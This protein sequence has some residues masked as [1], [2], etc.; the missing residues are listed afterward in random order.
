MAGRFG[1]V[2]F[3]GHDPEEFTSVQQGLHLPS[4]VCNMSFGSGA[5]KS[6]GTVN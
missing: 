2:A 1:P 5:L 3:G 6:S 4:N